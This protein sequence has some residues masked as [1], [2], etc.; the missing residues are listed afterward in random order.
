MHVQFRVAHVLSKGILPLMPFPPRLASTGW[1]CLALPGRKWKSKTSNQVLNSMPPVWNRRRRIRLSFLSGNPCTPTNGAPDQG[2]PAGIGPALRSGVLRD[3]SAAPRD[4][5]ARHRARRASAPCRGSRGVSG[6]CLPWTGA[7]LPHRFRHP[8][9][10]TS[11]SR[12][13]AM[14]PAHEGLAGRDRGD[15]NPWTPLAGF[16][17]RVVKPE[18][19]LLTEPPNRP[20]EP[21]NLQNRAIQGGAFCRE[22]ALGTC[23]TGLSTLP[24]IPRP[25]SEPLT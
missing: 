23:L 15:S 5:S 6:I 7:G 18:R 2:A 14:E 3:P 22:F 13:Q 4:C 21:N 12:D 19:G 24:I 8:T 1:C 17:A 11:R 25:S 20:L 16:R 10:A 9:G